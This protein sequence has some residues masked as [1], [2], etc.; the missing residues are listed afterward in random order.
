MDQSFKEIAY[1]VYYI[2]DLCKLMCTIEFGIIIMCDTC[3]CRQDTSM[4]YTALCLYTREYKNFWTTNIMIMK[5]LKAHFKVLIIFIHHL[6]CL[7]F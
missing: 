6:L 7:I 3:L 4:M 2:K 1:C 5:H